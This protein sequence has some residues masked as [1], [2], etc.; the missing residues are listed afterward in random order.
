[1]TA[2][3]NR[4]RY[5]RHAIE[6]DALFSPLGAPARQ[7]RVEDF[8]EAGVLVQ[9]SDGDDA[10]PVTG[11][12]VHIHAKLTGK[13]GL[14]PVTMVGQVVWARNDYFGM[15]F[16]QPSSELLQRLLNHKQAQQQPFQ[17][18][19]HAS[20]GEV[21]AKARMR[22]VAKRLLPAVLRDML[23]ELNERLLDQA[24]RAS[25][26]SEQSQLF[27]DMLALDGLRNSDR[28]I[29][30]VL[31]EGE[32]D[33][34][35]SAQPSTVDELTLVDPDEFERWLESSRVATSLERRFSKQLGALGSRLAALHGDDA[36]PALHTPFEPQ[37]FTNAVK[38]V[39]Q[40]LAVGKTTRAV[41]FGAVNQVLGDRLADFYAE[42]DAAL[43]AI[44]A[45]AARNRPLGGGNKAVV[46]QSSAGRLPEDGSVAADAVSESAP[47]TPSPAAERW[48]APGLSVAVDPSVIAGAQARS[49]AQRAEMA[50]DLLQQV[51]NLPGMTE[52]LQSWLALLGDPLQKQAIADPQ[53]FHQPDHPLR[54]IIDAL[55]HLQMFRPAPDAPLA[56]DETRQRVNRLLEPIARGQNDEHTV[57]AVAKGLNGLTEEQSRHYQHN[58]ERVVEASDGQER[59]RSSRAR[60]V[61]LL[62]ERYAGREVP[63]VVLDLLETGWRS[64]LELAALRE[65]RDGAGFANYLHLVDVLVAKLGGEAYD[66]D[67]GDISSDALLEGVGTE[68]ANT[69]FDPFRVA[70]VEKRL[71]SELLQTGNHP[72]R[73]V[74]FAPLSEPTDP[75]GSLDVPAGI[76]ADAWPRIL[77]SCETIHV[78]D[79]LRFLALD[80]GA[81]NGLRVAWIRQDR[82]LFTLVDYRGLKAR[83]IGRAELALGLYRRE[84]QLEQVDGKPLTEQALDTLLSRME[85]RLSHQASH[86][87]LTGLINRNQFK[88]ALEQVLR[89]PSRQPGALLWIDI[90]QFRLVNDMHGFE[91]GD[92]LL[93]AVARLL[94]QARGAQ[95]LAHVGADKFAVFCPDAAVSDATGY[96]EQ[97][98]NKV[99]SMPFRVADQ[100]L[101]ASISVG[102][103]EVSA[104]DSA[105]G[106]LLQ[107]ADDA[108]S[109]A[110]ANGGNRVYCYKDDDPEIQKHRKSVEW[111]VRVDDALER[112][113]LNLRCQPIVPVRADAGLVAH[114][115][116]LLGVSDGNRESLPIAEFIDAAERYNRMRSVD[117][118]VTRTVMEWI[119]AN[120]VVMPR[121]QGLAVNLSGQTASDPAF[122]DF[123][124]EQ[125]QRTEIDPSWL[126][127]EVTETAAVADLATSAGIVQDLKRL[128]CHVALDDFG[129]GLASYSYLK[130][131]PVDW[132]KIDGAFV[133][134]IAADRSDYAVVKSINEIGQFLGK[135]TI[136]EYVADEKIL[137][138]VAE[139][140]VD[141]AQGY[142]ISRPT[143]LDDLLDP[144]PRTA[145]NASARGA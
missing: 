51:Q 55:G 79:R 110:K 143:L 33:L 49:S 99:V 119:A 136:A 62:N 11:Q 109:A 132:L 126:S 63:E 31:E 27:A 66:C 133:R 3:I 40:E 116:V 83:D 53:L 71:R 101:S 58:V 91:A 128:G 23:L 37:Q 13:N 113:Q 48:G 6:L 16:E 145:I 59:I 131:L 96:A 60:V 39:A 100:T 52:S 26:N 108:L 125:F 35:S 64:V 124:R 104:A 43:D 5:P 21:R 88:A 84:V 89:R 120:R 102:L 97:L 74:R 69:A 17:H 19:A 29:N 14:R 103:V 32:R 47:E 115:E 12:M 82:G 67:P 85:Q 70:A 4:R 28:L 93:V 80:A 86:D 44:G 122:I 90:D 46:A 114:Y 68:L 106:V 98:R 87:S 25:S 77:A 142:A 81:A 56:S 8:C 107:A 36:S 76:S 144:L 123:I 129:S 135:Q 7:C 45:P 95:V 41:L 20:S 141:Y 127:F 22:Q 38:L 111:V 140:G 121:V 54:E 24:D 138:L 137:N 92:R 118:W 61:A 2:N 112:G 73:L 139:I 94:E 134:K 75:A 105:L 78:G 15:A 10:R 117:R 34:D 1:M 57:Q 72:V 42:L 130:E 9:C 50:G 18:D 30:A 65:G